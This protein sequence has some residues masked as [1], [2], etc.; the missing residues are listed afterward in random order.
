MGMG[1][2]LEGCA[3]VWG[4]RAREAGATG[5]EDDWLR[6]QNSDKPN[7]DSDVTKPAHAHHHNTPDAR[8]YPPTAAP[9][10]LLYLCAPSSSTPCINA[11]HFTCRS[12]L[13]AAPAALVAPLSAAHQSSP[14][15]TTTT[16]SPRHRLHPRTTIPPTRVLCA[17]LDIKSIVIVGN[18]ARRYRCRWASAGQTT[19]GLPSQSRQLAVTALSYHKSPLH[20]VS[21]RS[22]ASQRA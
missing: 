22:L 17:A 2:G 9:N 21:R 6:F 4:L 10:F 18:I 15:L 12:C 3:V 7:K 1:L 14:D 19:K 8:I 20:L 16:T 11:A 5:G 13:A